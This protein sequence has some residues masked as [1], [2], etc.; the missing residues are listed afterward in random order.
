[1]S[2]LEVGDDLGNASKETEESAND[3]DK[4]LKLVEKERKQANFGR[5]KHDEE[6]RQKEQRKITKQQFS[7][8]VH[9]SRKAI[10]RAFAPT[11]LME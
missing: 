7:I 2:L 3:G 8:H 6:S 4:N 5:D 9:V 1:M 11:L 10:H